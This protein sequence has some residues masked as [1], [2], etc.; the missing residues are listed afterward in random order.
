M[1]RNG[2]KGC[3]GCTTSTPASRKSKTHPH[4]VERLQPS[5][6]QDFIKRSYCYMKPRRRRELWK[7]F[8]DTDDTEM[9]TVLQT[10]DRR[11]RRE[12]W[13]H[14]VL[15]IRGR[16]VTTAI[17]LSKLPPGTSVNIALPQRRMKRQPSTR[18]SSSPSSSSASVEDDDDS[19][20][21]ENE[22]L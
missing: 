5:N 14:V 21:D 4:S 11:I 22:C 18:A 3:K 8:R 1:S 17:D 12:K 19:D 9:G 16:G 2:R 13:N 15:H 10:A 20:D 6:V 7:H